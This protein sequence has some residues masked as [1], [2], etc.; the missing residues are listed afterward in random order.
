MSD[1]E[2]NQEK[3]EDLK[4]DSESTSAVSTISYEVENAMVKGVSKKKI[5]AKLNNLKDAGNFPSNLD[6]VDSFYDPKTSSSGV[7]FLDN[8]TGK[9][10]VGFAGTNFDNGFF[11][12]GSKDVGQWGNIAFKGD[13]PS[14]AYFDASNK[15][16]N[17]LKANGFNVDTVTGHSLGGRNGTI[18][19]MAHNIP[20]IILYNSAPLM[21]VLTNVPTKGNLSNAKEL[22]KLLSGYKGNIIYF[23]SEDD[24]LNKVSGVG[25]S[26][27]PGKIIIIKN[28]KA[29]DITGFLTKKEQEFI[30]QHTPDLNKIYVAQQKVQTNT[31]SKLKALDVLRAKLLKSGGGLSASEEIYLDASEALILTQGMSKT[32]QIEIND[33]KKMYR[34]AKKDADKLWT[35]TLKTADS[36]GSTLHQG[37]VVDSLNGGGATE[38][39]VRIEPKEEYEQKISEL[40][41]IQQEYHGLIGQIQSSINKQV[42]TDQELARQI[43]G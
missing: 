25:G 26:V 7:A 17:D 30:R 27:Y 33:I 14:S 4:T 35:D 8:N 15:F 28:G 16:M 6:Y 11:G 13:G 2:F 38:P 23:V 9:V 18:M 21:N 12:E 24:P 42:E 5:V 39:I 43:G 10:V 37:E 1:Y 29:H 3:I 31:R 41:S 22:E 19:G 20:N 36:I 34:E 32:L 40:S